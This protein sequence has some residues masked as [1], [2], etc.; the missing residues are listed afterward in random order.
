MRASPSCTTACPRSSRRSDYAA[1]LDPA[2]EV[3]ALAELLA[4]LASDALALRPV[5]TRVNRVEND[6]AALLDAVPE[7]PRQ[8]SLF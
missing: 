2:R 7:P 4:P 6:D 8:P 5:G 3:A 1:W